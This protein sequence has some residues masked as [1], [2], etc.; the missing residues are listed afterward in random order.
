MLPIR[1]LVTTSLESTW[2]KDAPVVFLDEGCC[3]YDRKHIWKKMDSVVVPYHWADRK[4]LNKDYSYLCKLYERLLLCAAAWFNK[5]HNV[6]YSTRYWRILIG[7]WLAYY[8]HIIFDRWKMLL[9][10]KK[11][12][13][14]SKTVILKYENENMIPFDMDDFVGKLKSDEWNH[15]ICGKI[16]ERSLNRNQIIY[17]EPVDLK[18]HKESTVAPGK[19]T[20][21][22]GFR[23]RLKQL[24]KKT[25]LKLG[26]NNKYFI[27]HSYLSA[28]NYFSLNL[29]LKNFPVFY[30]QENVK[31][32]QPNLKFR[33]SLLFDFSPEG[34]FECFISE[35]LLFQVPSCFLEGYSIL[36][37]QVD[38]LL[39]AVNPKII[40]SSNFL[41]H[42]TVGMAYTASH[43]ERGTKLVYGQHGGVYGQAEFTWAE[44]HEIKISDKY[45][46][47][48][49]KKSYANNVLPIGILSGKYIRKDVRSDQKE[50]LLLILTSA[51]RYSY[52][53]DSSVKK[54]NL[55]YIES[56]FNFVGALTSSL[57]T[58]SLYIRHHHSDN[59]WGQAMRWKDAYP[60][61]KSD[62]GTVPIDSLLFNT[63]IAVYTCNSTGYLEY[64]AKNIP[65][66]VIFSPDVEPLRN[67]AIP[68]FKL[69]KNVG[70]YHETA[71]SAAEYINTI[72]DN[73]D[74]W[75]NSEGVQKARSDFC[76]VYAFYNDDLLGSIE[77]AFDALTSSNNVT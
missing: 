68:F 71:E 24:I 53:L 5:T 14:I 45:L 20:L 55:T 50:H 40:F 8:L 39:W 41:L 67:S 59:G 63:R 3:L 42:D 7:P 47:W 44:D 31:K 18:M 17:K 73:V 74:A 25:F 19:L 65:T 57:R 9:E 32:I 72:W 77:D 1:E 22:E 26:R 49:W 36:Q 11:I 52:R 6:N 56:T 16:L 33:D 70:I 64:L 10:A 23:F 12:C 35:N 58:D 38:K 2:T 69:L 34:D 28:R 54:I 29:R 60:E 37:E 66:I 76:K 61:V 30:Q 43:L 27:A 13:S 48:G 46:T 15:Y 51:P 21:L 62:E 4:K 75:W